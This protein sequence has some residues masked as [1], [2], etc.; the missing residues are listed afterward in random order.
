M[1]FYEVVIPRSISFSPPYSL[2]TEG[3]V[4]YKRDVFMTFMSVPSLSI[5]DVK[6]LSDTTVSNVLP[7][8]NIEVNMLESMIKEK[9]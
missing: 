3:I 6:S 5:N 7:Y 9:A 1:K 4:K 8:C 2:T